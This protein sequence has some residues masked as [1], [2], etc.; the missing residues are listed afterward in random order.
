MATRRLVQLVGGV[1]AT[2]FTLAGGLVLAAQLRPVLD[3]SDPLARERAQQSVR[4]TTAADRMQT[5]ARLA[6]GHDDAVRAHEFLTGISFSR[7]QLMRRAHGDVLEVSLG[8][9]SQTTR[10]F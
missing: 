6:R 10:S 7:S 5:F 2:S 8:D 4:E 3:S 9:Q 1:A